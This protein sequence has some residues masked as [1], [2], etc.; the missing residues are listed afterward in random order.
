VSFA[1]LPKAASWEHRGSHVGFEVAYFEHTDGTRTVEGWTTAVEGGR[2]WMVTY[3]IRLDAAWRTL[4]ASLHGRSVSGA[5]ATVL[6]SDGA[7]SWRV[8]DQP[9]PLRDGCLDVDLESSALTNAFPVQRLKLSVG[10]TASAPAAYIR[11]DLS[12]DRLEQEYVRAADQPPGQRYLYSAPAFS[13]SCALRYD[14]SGVVLEY[15]GIA[16]RAS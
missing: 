13:F 2:P 1:E 16:A 11:T 8:D 3:D 10:E 4:R 5:G 6:E 15:P 7:G 14:Q 12:V 9:A